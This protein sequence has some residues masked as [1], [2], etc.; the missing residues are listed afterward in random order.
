[1]TQSYEGKVNECCLG[2]FSHCLIRFWHLTNLNQSNIF[3]PLSTQFLIFFSVRGK[4]TSQD[5]IYVT[6]RKRENIL[7]RKLARNVCVKELD[8]DF[9]F[10]FNENGEGIVGQRWENNIEEGK[11]LPL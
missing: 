8:G 6:K 3:L 5:E 11:E 1:M 2:F 10:Q 9:W 7:T 4:V